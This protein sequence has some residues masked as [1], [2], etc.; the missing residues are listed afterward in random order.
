MTTDKHRYNIGEG[1]DYILSIHEEGNQITGGRLDR[2]QSALP[3]EHGDGAHPTRS[4]IKEL[5]GTTLETLDAA[6]RSHIASQGEDIL[7]RVP[8]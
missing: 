7:C 3:H 6:V 5:Q 4:T 1:T 8:A 2:E